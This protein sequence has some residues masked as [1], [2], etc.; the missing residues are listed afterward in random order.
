M[1]SSTVALADADKKL[2]QFRNCRVLRNHRLV[3]D[4]VWV[5]GGKIIDP[6][7]VFFDEKR[8]ADVQIDCGGSIVAPG[9]IDLQINGNSWPTLMLVRF[10]VSEPSYTYTHIFQGGYGVDFSFD[11]ETVQEGVLKVAKGLLAHGVTSFCPTLVTSPP[12]TYHAVLPRIPRT[13]G[14]RHG[15][16][17]LGCHVEGPFINTDKKGAHPPECIKEFEQVGRKQMHEKATERY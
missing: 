7:K 6:E 13:A 10:V 15:A 3:E 14:G 2:T 9:F 4:D 8:Q 16:T 11:V 5:R 1:S 17:V 12:E